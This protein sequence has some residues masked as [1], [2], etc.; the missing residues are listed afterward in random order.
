MKKKNTKKLK[1]PKKRSLLKRGKLKKSV[2]AS[3]FLLK[4]IILLSFIILVIIIAIGISVQQNKPTI[5]QFVCKGIVPKN[6]VLCSNDD[7]GL[8][9]N[10]SITLAPFCTYETKCQYICG[11][12]YKKWENNCVDLNAPINFCVGDVPK[13]AVLCEEDNSNLEWSSLNTLVSSCT[14][15]KKCEYVCESGFI[16]EGARCLREYCEPVEDL[17]F[18]GSVIAITSQNGDFSSGV[19]PLGTKTAFFLIFN[20][21][22]FIEAAKNPYSQEESDVERNVVQWLV[23]K[24]VEK[25]VLADADIEFA[26]KIGAAGIKCLKITGKIAAIIGQEENIDTNKPVSYNGGQLVI[27]GKDFFKE[28]I[29]E[30]VIQ[31]SKGGT[32]SSETFYLNQGDEITSKDFNG[33][34]INQESIVFALCPCSNLSSIQIDIGLSDSNDYSYLKWKTSEEIKLQATIICDN[35]VS[36]LKETLSSIGKVVSI[37]P[38][39]LCKPNTSPCCVVMPRKSIQ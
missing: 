25:I 37:D 28:V 16:K 3:H 18:S 10:T 38:A 33:K 32:Q 7:I 20:N 39:G 36:T 35:N 22:K 29:E 11:Q 8:I 31:L 24:N 9:K 30:S 6:A 15:D 14:P 5:G 1:A 21:N 34:G 27:N 17:N 23:D 4:K 12:E 19:S 2:I 26:S 13:N